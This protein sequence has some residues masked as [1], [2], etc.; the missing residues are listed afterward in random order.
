[1]SA[2]T[3]PQGEKRASGFFGPDK[4]MG[5]VGSVENTNGVRCNL[6]KAYTGIKQ[7]PE[8]QLITADYDTVAHGVVTNMAKLGSVSVTPR[9]VA[10]FAKFRHKGVFATTRERLCLPSYPPGAGEWLRTEGGSTKLKTAKPAML[11]TL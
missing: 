7:E 4:K 9:L 8:P 6:R 3:P 5:F 2:P 10:K 11:N 1:M